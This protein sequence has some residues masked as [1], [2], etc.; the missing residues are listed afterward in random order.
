M[1][2]DGLDAGDFDLTEDVPDGWQL[3]QV[4]CAIGNANTG[5]PIVDGVEL[6]LDWGDNVE[7]LFVNTKLGDLSVEKSISAPLDPAGGHE[8]VRHHLRNRRHE[9]FLHG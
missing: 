5:S 9:R 4:S 2:F 8:P 1:V 3:S 6:S 7:C